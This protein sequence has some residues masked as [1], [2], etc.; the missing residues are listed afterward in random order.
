M[1]YLQHT[2]TYIEFLIRVIE[3]LQ[4]VATSN[5]SYNESKIKVKVT[6]RQAVEAYRFVEMLKIPHCIDNVPQCL[7]LYAT[8]C[9][10]PPN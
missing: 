4:I 9:P 5:Y 6:L 7:N 1:E 10:P 8:P 2:Q 3:H